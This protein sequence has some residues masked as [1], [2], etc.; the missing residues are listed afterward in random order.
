MILKLPPILRLSAAK[1]AVTR[2]TGW[3]ADVIQVFPICMEDHDRP[4]F[5]LD[6]V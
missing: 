1:H 5:I 3:S 6:V 2:I 4:L